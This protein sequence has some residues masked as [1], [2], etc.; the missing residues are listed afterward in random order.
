MLI[1]QLHIFCTIEYNSDG[2]CQMLKVDK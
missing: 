2:Q 1:S